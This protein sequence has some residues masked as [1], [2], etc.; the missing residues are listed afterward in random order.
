MK[1]WILEFIREI[2]TIDQ[3]FVEKLQENVKKF[4]EMQKEFLRKIHNEQ[5]VRDD[6]KKYVSPLDGSD[7]DIGKQTKHTKD[8][9]SFHSKN[10]MP[11][12]NRSAAST[13]TLQVK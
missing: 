10:K 3:F 1:Q 2:D 9:A 11:N 7:I 4:I 12:I 5:R 6:E 8:Q 13:D